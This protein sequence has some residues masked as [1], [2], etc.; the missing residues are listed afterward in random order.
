MSTLRVAHFYPWQGIPDEF[1]KYP[2]W[3]ESQAAFPENGL[4]FLPRESWLENRT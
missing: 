2:H 1:V 4:F 3:E